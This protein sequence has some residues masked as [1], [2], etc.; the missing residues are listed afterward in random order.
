MKFFALML[1]LL[2]SGCQSPTDFNYKWHAWE[3]DTGYHVSFLFRAAPYYWQS[4]AWR[5]A[6]CRNA[7]STVLA[8][9]KRQ[10]IIAD[11]GIILGGG[12]EE[13]GLA[14]IGLLIGDKSF[15][16]KWRGSSERDMLNLMRLSVDKPWTANG[17]GRLL[18]DVVP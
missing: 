9:F 4:K 13:G 12:G 16:T 15:C 1:I 14:G 3:F 11:D 2:V 18:I 10:G 6:A 5:E 8:D 7:L 17:E